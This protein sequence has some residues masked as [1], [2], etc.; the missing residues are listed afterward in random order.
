MPPSV[1]D[2][3]LNAVRVAWMQSNHAELRHLIQADPDIVF[4]GDRSAVQVMGCGGL[5]V[6]HLRVSA[7]EARLI[8]D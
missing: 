4:N 5:V 6:A 3:K 2:A 8:S 1:M 7:R